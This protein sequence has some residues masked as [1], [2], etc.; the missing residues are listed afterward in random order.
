MKYLVTALA[1]VAWTY[2][3]DNGVRAWT[4]DPERVPARYW[5]SHGEGPPYEASERVEVGTIW[6]YHRT[7]IVVPSED[8]ED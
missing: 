3:Q 6:D 8:R 2:V 1:L 4:D 5:L 7:T